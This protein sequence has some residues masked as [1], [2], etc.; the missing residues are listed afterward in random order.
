MPIKRRGAD[1]SRLFERLT[2][3]VKIR[4]PDALLRAAL[5]LEEN[6]KRILDT[7]PAR[8][9]RVYGKHQAS[10]PGE[11]PAPDTRGLLESITHEVGTAAIGG[12]GRLGSGIASSV[13]VGTNH[14]AAELL[15]FG[16]VKM[17]PRPHA[18]PALAASRD[19]MKGVVVA[20]L[21]VR[22]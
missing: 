11:P 6:W 1:P 21:R 8:T 18:R 14:P 20:E 13:R 5:V 19:E 10:A 22:E 4:A 15:E 16:T 2:D 12:R 17:A 3:R 7:P 9:G